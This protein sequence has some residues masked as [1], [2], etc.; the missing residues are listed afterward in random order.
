MDSM[1]N[2]FFKTP[3][4]QSAAGCEGFSLIEVL[5][6]TVI[7]VIGLLSLTALFATALG[8]VQSSQDSQIA[9]QKARE[10]LESIYA[11]R[12]DQT[13]TFS[14]IANVSATGPGIFNSGFQPMYLAGANGIPG[15]TSDTTILDRVVLPGKDG[16]MQT[17]AGAATPA[18]DDVFVPLSNFRRQVLITP[19]SVFM[20]KIVVTIRVTAA[21]GNSRDF[22]TSGYI[23][24]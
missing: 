3:K 13:I 10:T 17:A 20:S 21:N 15:T 9:R 1:K 7:L 5:I 14:Q 24:Q 12:N 23:S 16:I 2:T 6:A 11:A 8:A 4:R 22:V 19:V 18:G